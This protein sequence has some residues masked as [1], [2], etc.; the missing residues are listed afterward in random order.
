MTL[1]WEEP[2]E[3]KGGPVHDWRAI[4]EALRSRPNEWAMAVICRNSATAGSTA[5]L[6]R[7]GRYDA[8]G[9]GFEAVARTVGGEARVYARYVGGEVAS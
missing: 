7:R 3:Q 5:L 9:S 1:R 4:G 6:I 8:L 2:P